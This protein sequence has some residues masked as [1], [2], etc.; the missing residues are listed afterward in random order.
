M[1]P[2]ISGADLESFVPCDYDFTDIEQMLPLYIVT[3]RN[4]SE[5]KE[6]RIDVQY[7]SG[8]M[9]FWFDNEDFN[10]QHTFESESRQLALSI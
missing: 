3:G 10:S 4:A 5:A 7:P 6:R 1:R 2:A 8:L 9:P